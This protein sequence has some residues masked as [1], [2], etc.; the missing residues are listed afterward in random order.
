MS[1]APVEQ[2]HWTS[3]RDEQQACRQELQEIKE[4]LRSIVEESRPDNFQDHDYAIGDSQPVRLSLF[5]MRRIFIMP[6]S[7]LTILVAGGSMQIAA[8][9][10]VWTNITFPEGTVIFTTGTSTPVIARFRATNKSQ[11]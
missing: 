3:L 8:A 5:G 2:Q 11:P 7:A 6:P 4:L 9:Q 1:N 10:N